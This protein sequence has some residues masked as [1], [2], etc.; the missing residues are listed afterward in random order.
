MDFL[1]SCRTNSRIS[2]AVYRPFART[3]SEMSNETP[4][5]YKTRAGA[6]ARCSAR[7]PLRLPWRHLSTSEMPHHTNPQ[8][9]CFI[10]MLHIWPSL[11]VVTQLAFFPPPSLGGPALL[12]A[13]FL[14][15][16]RLDAACWGQGF[17]VASSSLSAVTISYWIF[18]R[19]VA[20]RCP[21]VIVDELQQL[22]RSAQKFHLAPA[23]RANV[24]QPDHPRSLRIADRSGLSP[25]RCFSVLNS[26]CGLAPG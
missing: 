21:K 6:R 8:H 5:A 3:A 2:M 25:T 16:Y 26:Q 22:S 17:Q 4:F 19:I 18:F 7:C 12:E 15:P 10:S 13:I 11:L 9:R 23:G 1:H 14:P 20:T 24:A